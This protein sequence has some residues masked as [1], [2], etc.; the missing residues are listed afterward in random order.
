VF[1]REIFKV[2]FKSWALQRNV[3]FSL[4]HY[5][6]RLTEHG[7][8]HVAVRLQHHSTYS[9]LLNC[10]SLAY[11]LEPI[12]V[13]RLELATADVPLSFFH[14]FVSQLLESPFLETSTKVCTHAIASI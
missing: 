11:Y 3:H 7:C 5:W 2:S 8:N 14:N 13:G 12:S 10:V 4:V 9:I 6:S 1:S